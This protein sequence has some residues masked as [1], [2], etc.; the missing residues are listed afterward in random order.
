MDGNAPNG[1]NGA[2]NWHPPMAPP[3]AN[4]PP[5]DNDNENADPMDAEHEH[6]DAMLQNPEFQ[7]AASQALADDDDE[8][9]LA[10]GA[11][12]PGAAPMEEVVA[13]LT[14]SYPAAPD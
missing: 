14:Q 11:A 7:N 5:A 8:P 4:P 9:G 10:D 3:P 6:A 12:G 2:N 13:A 1:A